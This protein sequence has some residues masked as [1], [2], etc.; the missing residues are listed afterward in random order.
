MNV[1][2]KLIG[3]VTHFSSSDIGGDFIAYCRHTNL[4][5]WHYYNDSF[6]T[7][8]TAQKKDIKITFLIFYDI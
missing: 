2:Y 6:I 4:N 3:V 7:K 8:L 1:S 5:E